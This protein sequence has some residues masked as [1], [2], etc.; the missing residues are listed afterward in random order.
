MKDI[1]YSESE[2]ILF[3]VVGYSWIDNTSKVQEIID[4][5]TKKRTEFLSIF[6]GRKLPKNV[7][8]NVK[9]AEVRESRRYKHMRIFYLEHI[10]P[11]Q[12]PENA[13]HITNENGWTMWKWLTD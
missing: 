8:K 11:E 1:F 7:E 12:V 10:K 6:D 9:S 3:W 2:N 13:F 5:F 4:E